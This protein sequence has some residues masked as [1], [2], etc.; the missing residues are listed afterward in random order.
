MKQ[1]L[2]CS[3][4]LLLLLELM[5]LYYSKVSPDSDYLD[6]LSSFS[7]QK[8]MPLP[9][10]VIS[11]LLGSNKIKSFKKTYSF[12]KFVLFFS[13]REKMGGGRRTLTWLD[14]RLL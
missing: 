12:E 1:N 3:P 10:Y 8:I 4:I 13:M 7:D 9:S 2:K 14:T 6:D 11:F 5:I